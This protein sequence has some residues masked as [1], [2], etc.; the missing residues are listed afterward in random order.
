VPRVKTR[1]SCRRMGMACRSQPSSHRGPY[2][3]FGAFHDLPQTES[4]TL[5]RR[6]RQ[7]RPPRVLR[8][9]SAHLGWLPPGR[10]RWVRPPLRPNVLPLTRSVRRTGGSVGTKMGRRTSSLQWLRSVP[11]DG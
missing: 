8:R 5:Q 6:A 3:A 10:V 9:R 2:Q 4:T 7:R 1:W 11:S